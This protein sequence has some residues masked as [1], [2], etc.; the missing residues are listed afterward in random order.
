MLKRPKYERG[1]IVRFEASTGVIV[2]G[3]VYMIDIYGYF[4]KDGEILYD[5]KTKD[6]LYKHVRED[7]LEKVKSVTKSEWKSL[8]ERM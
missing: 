8:V 1:D 3:E 7:E 4:I 6:V 2:T 5:I